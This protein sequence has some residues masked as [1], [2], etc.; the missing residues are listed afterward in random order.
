MLGLFI[1]N[2]T[3]VPTHMFESELLQ[4]INKVTKHSSR[5][6]RVSAEKT[7]GN[8]T[9]MTRKQSPSG[10]L[11]AGFMP[12]FMVYCVIVLHSF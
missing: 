6:R 8:Y 3:H 7:C 12:L 10:A 4:L 2:C 11:I 5:R 1:F 9:G